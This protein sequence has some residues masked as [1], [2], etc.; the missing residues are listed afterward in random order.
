MLTLSKPR[1]TEDQ[2]RQGLSRDPIKSNIINSV[3][4]EREASPEVLCVIDRCG[5]LIDVSENCL[6][7]LGY[8]VAELP[9][10]RFRRFL[11]ADDRKALDIKRGLNLAGRPAWSFSARC[12][13]KTG[14]DVSMIWSVVWVDADQQFYCTGW[15]LTEQHRLQDQLRQAQRLEAVG[16]LTGGM[17]HDF[18]NLLTV[19]IGGAESLLDE[20]PANPAVRELAELIYTA[21]M[22]GSELTSQLLAFARRQP[23][24]PRSVDISALLS[25]MRVLL[26]RAVNEGVELLL[27]HDTQAW[28]PL[29]D[30]TQLESAIL[31]LVINARDAMPKGGKL[32]IETANVTLDQAYVDAN[33]D[34]APGKYLMIAVTD[35][36]EGMSAE[37][38]DQAFE[39]FF[40]TKG[41]GKGTGLGLSMIYGFAKQSKGN[42]KIYSELGLGTTIKLYLPIA[43]S[44]ERDAEKTS[45]DQTLLLGTEHILL[46][47][48]DDLLREHVHKQLIALGYRVTVARNG[49]DAIKKL[50]ETETL[51]LL[52]TDVVMPG[53]MNG[54]QLA[55]WARTLKP[56]LR[57]LYTS[58]YTEN[59]IVHHGQLDAGVEL[60]NKPY[61]KRDLAV[62]LR[63]VLTQTQSA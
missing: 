30:P 20:N 25:G 4:R 53:G 36:G 43:G 18:N 22:R 57:V 16:R 51:D 11:N 52:F 28:R 40:T 23:L 32:T 31:N 50:R 14:R 37:T 8:D 41:T 5:R 12:R 2:D 59:A 15:D 9:T 1:N 21:G 55:D 19:I 47:E 34:I 7:V 61:R 17:A 63:K 29:V 56:E 58:G 33:I 27:A 45:D 38:A 35:N 6:S 10:Q 26:S 13:H 48:D 60:L 62:K 42:V 54:R 49:P 3:D 46:V 39:P 24:E 44:N